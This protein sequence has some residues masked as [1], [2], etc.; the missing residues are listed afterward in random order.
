[1]GRGAFLQCRRQKKTERNFHG[2][3]S[4][5]E[6]AAGRCAGRG[7]DLYPGR[8]FSD[9]SGHW[10]ENA[11]SKWSEEYGIINGYDDGTFRPD[12]S[13]T[14]GA[15]AGILDRFLK[16]Q[17][18]SPA[19]TF[20]DTPRTYWETEILKLHASGVY[21]GNNG[22]AL[23]ADTITRQQAVAMIARS[24]QI[25]GETTT[26]TYADGDQVAEYAKGYVAEMTRRGYITDS[27]NGYFRP[28]DPITR[29]EIV[30]ILSN[31]VDVL[32]QSTTPYSKD[33]N[34]T[35]MINS[36]G[37]A[38]LE[39]MK[40][41]GDLILA[42]GVQ[43]TVSLE[44]VTIQGDVRNFGGA[45]I[46]VVNGSEQGTTE[47]STPQ[48]PDS[49][50]SSTPSGTY[51]WVDSYGYVSYNGYQVPLYD[52]VDHN[53][54]S[55]GDFVWDG[56]RLNYVGGAYKT[57][58]GI[59][60]SAYQNRASENNTIDWEAVAADG[61]DFAM[62]RVGLRGYTSGSLVSDAFYAK[63]IDGA[64][65]AGIDTGVYIFSQAITVEEAVEEADY[66]ISLLKGHEISGPVAYDW[67][68]HDSTY[69]VYGIS[70][71]V[72]TACAL[73]FCKRIEAAGYQPMIYMSQYVGY[74]KFNLPQLTDYPIWYPEYKSASS[75]KL[76]PGF[77]YQ[78]D[79]W[80]FSSSCSIDGI[81][82][83]VD[84]N[85]QFIG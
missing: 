8:C 27:K 5:A 81:G 80:Q 19:S 6:T 20:S 11:I 75:T 40:I 33:T 44:N 45:A 14:R 35:L 21:L 82:G 54:L 34:G 10:A 67:E 15:F 22:M 38:T 1:M 61:V 58:F 17:T 47:P 48:N 68:M 25:E 74:N 12:Q 37:G 69:R 71:E 76:Y 59:D 53:S 77:Y 83:K 29:A 52:G 30:N 2:T 13:I 42:P 16:F 41:S 39:N 26:L 62:V 79:I 65:A 46:T 63:N 55:Q 85:I 72:A 56:D 4:T 9:T 78:M 31:M 3:H 60:V 28:T 57:R 24:F 64:M 43:G 84:A 49:N 36:S 70:P 23:P 66:V 18:V 7:T 32:V 73:A 51:P 50:S